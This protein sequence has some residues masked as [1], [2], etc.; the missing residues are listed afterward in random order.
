MPRACPAAAPDAPEND[1]HQGEK[2]LQALIA[3]HSIAEAASVA[4]AL[5]ESPTI[6]PRI[7]AVPAAAD[8]RHGL[9]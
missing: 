2:P 7:G 6:D 3:A 5:T 8:P 9:L 4:A 1:F